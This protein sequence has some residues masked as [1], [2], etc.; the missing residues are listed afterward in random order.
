LTGT[1]SININGTVGATTPTTGAFTTVSATGVTTV[2]AGTAALPAITTSGDTNTGIFFPAADTI[3]FSEGGAEAMRIDSSGNV[4]IGTSSPTQRLTVKSA[5]N[6]S[7]LG[8]DNAGAQYTSFNIYNNGTNKVGVEYD[9]TNSHFILNAITASSQI[10][11]RTVDTERM[12]IDSSGNLGLGVTPSAWSEFKGLQ[13]SSTG[14]IA[15]NAFSASNTQTFFGNNVYYNTGYKYIATGSAA[16]QYLQ[17][18]DEH[19]WNAAPSGT[20]GNAITFTRAMTLDS[21]GN[22]LVGTT[23]GVGASKVISPTGFTSRSVSL[24]LNGTS[25]VTVPSGC[26][27]TMAS[28]GFPGDSAIFSIKSTGGSQGCYVMAQGTALNIG[29]GTTSNPSTGTRLNVWISA[30]NTMSIQDVGQGARTIYLTF[31][32]SS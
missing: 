21:S 26:I 7:Q 11:L 20:A 23:S 32:S 1:A 14:C 22:L 4:G 3:A 6:G 24:T 9:N 29:F 2:Q 17:I 27:C 15:S 12:R 5:T 31:T 8:I 13:I 16:A 28:D 25:T 30:D 18:G 10:I 19:Q